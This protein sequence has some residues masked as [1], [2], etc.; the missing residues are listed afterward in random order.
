[1]S[2]RRSASSSA[3]RRASSFFRSWYFAR[4]VGLAREVPDL[5]VDLVAQI[6]QA[7]EV[8]ARVRHARLGFL[9]ALLVAR[10]ARGFLDERAH[11]VASR[12]DDARDHA[13]FDDRVAARTQAGA[14]EQRRDVL[15]PA[16]RAVDE[17][18]RGA[19]A[20]HQAAQRHLGVV[21]V[22]AADLAVAVVEDQLYRRTADRLARVRAVEDHVRHRVAAQMLG[23]QLTHDPTHRVDDIRL[24]AAVR[25]DDAGEVLGE[26]DGRRID[27]RLEAGEFD[28][29]QAH[30]LIRTGAQWSALV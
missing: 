4:D 11:V 3:P 28:L 13:L 25:A 26:V 5:L 7:L 6:L 10:D 8:L 15:A 14:Q 17:V 21:G 1:M 20:R 18:G 27:E 30:L 23:G 24:A 19:V 29:R 2:R 12:L 9:A 22:G 16:T